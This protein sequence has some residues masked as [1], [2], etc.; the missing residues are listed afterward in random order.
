[1]ITN[2]NIENKKPLNTYNVPELMVV[3]FLGSADKIAEFS[4]KNSKQQSTIMNGY[5][6]WLGFTYN[7][8]DYNK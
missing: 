3:F 4:Y 2:F 8:E 7:L 1:M 5:K 6:R